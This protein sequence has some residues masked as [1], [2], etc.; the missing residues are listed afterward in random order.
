MGQGP[1]YRVMFRRRRQK[2]TDYKMRKAM[3]VSK[4]PRLVVRGSLAH[5]NIQIAEALL[6]GDRTLASANSKSLASFGWKAPSGNIPAAYLTGYLLGKKAL[7]ARLEKAILDVG[8]IG[9]T[10]GARLFAALKGVVD[11]GLI[12]P[13]GEDI[14]PLDQRIKGEHIA[15][16]AAKI[17]GL[18]SPMYDRRFSQYLSKGLRPEDLPEHFSGIKAAIDQ[19]FKEGS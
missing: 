19:A 10:T 1:R 2:R 9:T 8:L 14:L 18:D 5:M 6:N 3:V 16:Y 4:I 17:R 7:A 12:V 13:H 11:A 15:Q